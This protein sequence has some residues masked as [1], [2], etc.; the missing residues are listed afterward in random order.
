MNTLITIVA[1][2]VGAA[3]VLLAIL[4]FNWMYGTP[5]MMMLN[6]QISFPAA[7][8]LFVVMLGLGMYLDAEERREQA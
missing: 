3:V 7:T 4:G 1:M 6:P 2:L 8:T 5:G